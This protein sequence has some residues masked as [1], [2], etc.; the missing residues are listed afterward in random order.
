MNNLLSVCD[1]LFMTLHRRYERYFA[2]YSLCKSTLGICDPT[3]A[4]E[5]VVATKAR[6]LRFAIIPP[7]NIR[8]RIIML[9]SLVFD[10]YK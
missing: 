2:N 5:R 1:F 3:V 7:Q 8:G 9:K 6:P 4:K 10:F